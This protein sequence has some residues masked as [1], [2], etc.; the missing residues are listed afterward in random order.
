MH[1]PLTMQRRSALTGMQSCVMRRVVAHRYIMRFKESDRE[2]VRD[3]DR[4][5][6][7]HRDSERER[8]RDRERD[9]EGQREIQ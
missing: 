9:R 4:E 5:R 8:E 1:V 6:G 7:K 3:I 2:T